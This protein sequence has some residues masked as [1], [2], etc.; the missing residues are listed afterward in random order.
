MKQGGWGRTDDWLSDLR[1][2]LIGCQISESLWSV[3]SHSRFPWGIVRAGRV[4][5]VIGASLERG[6]GQ[7]WKRMGTGEGGEWLDTCCTPSLWPCLDWT[8]PDHCLHLYNIAW[9]LSL[10]L[11]LLL[12]LSLS[13][14]YSLYL[15]LSLSLSLTL[16]L[17]LS[18]SLSH[19]PAQSLCLAVASFSSVITI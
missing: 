9:L 12:S 11:T 3:C 4:R 18:L 7:G 15:S 19:S 6:W 10:S 1:V 13:L 17:S 2:S 8:S 5:E 14:S 16:L